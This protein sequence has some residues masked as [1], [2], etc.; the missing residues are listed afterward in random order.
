MIHKFVPGVRVGHFLCTGSGT[1]HAPGK[2]RGSGQGFGYGDGWGDS[3]GYFRYS[4]SWT[5]VVFQVAR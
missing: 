5:P 2:L 4:P 3:L 1:K